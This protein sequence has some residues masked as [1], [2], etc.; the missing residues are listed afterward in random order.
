MSRYLNKKLIFS[1]NSV[2]LKYSIKVGI[3]KYKDRLV[4]EYLL[5]FHQLMYQILI[6]MKFTIFILKHILTKRKIIIQKMF[7]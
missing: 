3:I 1:F 7:F 5:R 2:S 6:I 4:N